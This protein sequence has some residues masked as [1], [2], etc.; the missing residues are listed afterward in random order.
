MKRRSDY[1]PYMEY[2]VNGKVQTNK[3]RKKLLIEGLKKEVCECCGN[4]IWNGKKIPLEV[5]HIDGNKTNNN[6]DNLLLLCPNCHALTETYRG[7]N[8]KK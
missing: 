3:L 4:S 5:H 1:M 8:I 7:K 6:L 2:I